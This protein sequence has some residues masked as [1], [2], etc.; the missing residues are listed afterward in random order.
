[1]ET[2]FFSLREAVHFIE[3]DGAAVGG[4]GMN[5]FTDTCFNE[6]G[7]NGLTKTGTGASMASIEFLN[8]VI[9][10]FA[11]TIDHGGFTDTRGANQQ[12]CGTG[13]SFQ[14][15]DHRILDVWMKTGSILFG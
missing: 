11:D 2:T 5:P 10:L 3:E 9:G 8:P 12:K 14:P 15:F 1:L 4:R 13:A 6:E 7:H